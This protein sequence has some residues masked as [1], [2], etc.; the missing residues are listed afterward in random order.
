MIRVFLVDDHGL[1]RTGYRMLLES[2][3]DMQLL[4]EAGTG[5]E[6]LPAIRAL[7]PDVVVS[8]LHLPGMS[9]LELAERLLRVDDA[10]K[11]VIVSMQRDGP[12]P[13]R[14]LDLG[15][16]GYLTKDCEGQEV[17]RAIRDAVRGKRYVSADIAQQI[18]L[19]RVDGGRSPFD[20]LSARELEIAV[21]LA[22]G[23]RPADIAV[24]LSLSPKTVS[25]HK[26]RLFEKLGVSD[27]VALV[28]LARQYGLIED[29]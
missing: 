24:E 5:D 14:L 6:A 2:Q 15:V 21:R 7:R 3:P 11:L 27:T 8:D 29:D 4:G 19:A 12:M 13:R 22:R 28:R 9:G 23:Q 16:S 25:T 18:A 1:M 10:P 26:T 17:L 20:A